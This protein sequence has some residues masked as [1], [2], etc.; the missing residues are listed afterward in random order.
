MLDYLLFA[1]AFFASAIAPGADTFL[2]LSRA[3]V[4]RPSAVLTVF[5]IIAGKA[6]MISIIYLGL[7]ALLQSVTG[8]LFALQVIGAGYLIW[9]AYKLWNKELSFTEETQ[10]GDFWSAF[11]IAF[12]NPQPFAFYLSVIP[13]IVGGTALAPLLVIVVLGFGVIGAIYVLLASAVQGWLI[14]QANYRFI[15]RAMSIVF[16]TLAVII[17]TR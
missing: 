5:G 11:V 17:L 4:S 7:A 10:K 1:S 3:L 9:R 16:L 2:I 15:N 8:L 6:L 14:K 12:G 13:A